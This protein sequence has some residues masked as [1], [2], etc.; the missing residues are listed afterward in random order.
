VHGCEEVPGGQAWMVA[1]AGAAC[2]GCTETTVTGPEHEAPASGPGNVAEAA[3][4]ALQPDVS[5]CV[6]ML[7]HDGTAWGMALTLDN[8]A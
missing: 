4:T 6:A 8:T 5:A 2:G 7:E 1:C 3:V